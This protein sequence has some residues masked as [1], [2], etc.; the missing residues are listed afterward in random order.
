M[1]EVRVVRRWS[2]KGRAEPAVPP[3][4]IVPPRPAARVELIAIGASTGGPIVLQTILARLPATVGVP[5]L[6]VQHIAAG[7]LDGLADWLTQTTPIPTHVATP[8]QRPLPGHAYLAPDSYHM[9]VGPDGRIVLD[10][11]PPDDGLRPS[12][13]HLFTA[14]ARALGSRAVGVLLTGMGRDGADA[15]KLLRDKGALTIAQDRESS[16]VYGMPGEAE[17]IGAAAH[18]LG[19]EKIAAMLE[20]AVR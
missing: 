19:P 1:S 20:A 10:A 12:V 3:P 15:L 16:V 18:L 2:R 7:F 6:I 17:R 8:G 13:H 14:P 5:V 4:P 11:G 9:G